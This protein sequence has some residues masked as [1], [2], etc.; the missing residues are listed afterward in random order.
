[1]LEFVEE[2]FDDQQGPLRMVGRVSKGFC[3]PARTDLGVNASKSLTSKLS[4][5]NGLAFKVCST[6]HIVVERSFTVTDL[7]PNTAYIAFLQL[8]TN[9]SHT[10]PKWG[11]AGWLNFHLFLVE[12]DVLR[13]LLCSMPQRTLRTLFQ[14]QQS[15]CGCH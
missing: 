3:C 12:L 4:G 10:P 2:A 5:V 13:S 9:R 14:L 15:L 8:L 7:F 11:S 1:M 6:K